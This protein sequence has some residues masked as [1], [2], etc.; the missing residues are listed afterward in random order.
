MLAA[1]KTFA[2]KID[3][4]VKKTK[5]TVWQLSYGFSNIF[6]QHSYG[7]KNQFIRKSE[8]G[9]KYENKILSLV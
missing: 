6:K 9:G 4:Q 8:I 2:K 5:V 7:V 1:K 3:S